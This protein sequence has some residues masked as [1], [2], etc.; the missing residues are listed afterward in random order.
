MHMSIRATVDFNDFNEVDDFSRSGYIMV[1]AMN[2]HGKT[3]FSIQ[4]SIKKL[5]RSDFVLDYA[6]PEIA[7]HELEWEYLNLLAIDLTSK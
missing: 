1:C 7:T 5:I 4:A 2:G 6:K 3:L